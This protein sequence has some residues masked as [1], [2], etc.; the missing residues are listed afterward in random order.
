MMQMTTHK[1]TLD[2]QIDWIVTAIDLALVE[3]E[4]VM[5]PPA[6]EEDNSG[7]DH[8]HPGR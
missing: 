1:T 5:S 6:D 3:N 2:Q 7:H 8:T 4:R